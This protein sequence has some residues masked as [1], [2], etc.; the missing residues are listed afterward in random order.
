MKI[1]IIGSGWYGC[2]LAL[3][4]KKKGH[5]V[6]IYEKN[7]TIFSGI[8]GKF[9]IRLHA[10]PHYPR[11][12]ETRKSCQRGLI[13]FKQR[14]PDLVIEHEYSI[15]GLGKVDAEKNPSRIS[16]KQFKEVC[17]ETNNCFEIDPKMRGYQDL[18][19]VVEID[20][21]SIVLGD[22]L[23]NKFLLEL[24][25]AKIPI[26]FNTR[27]NN[28]SNNGPS[29]TIETDDEFTSF[30]RVINATGY[31][32]NI[33]N[34][35]DFPVPIEVTYQPCVALVYEDTKPDKKPFSF[36]IIDGWFPCLMPVIDEEE[37]DIIKSRKYILTHG[38]WTIMGS[39]SSEAEASTLLEYLDDDFIKNKIKTY[40]QHEMERFWPEFSERF[41][42]VGWKSEVIAKLK[43]KREFRSAI[44][45]EKNGVIHIIP[46][47]VS[48]IFDVEREINV[49]LE[50]K[51]ADNLRRTW[52]NGVSS[53]FEDSS[54]IL[55][56]NGYKYVKHG[57]LHGSMAEIIE[58]PSHGEPNTC[59]IQTFAEIQQEEKLT[60]R[61]QII[62]PPY[63]DLKLI[64]E[65]QNNIVED[66]LQ[67]TFFEIEC[68]AGIAGGL[69]MFALM[70]L[71]LPATGPA[72]A[73]ATSSAAVLGSGYC[74]YRLFNKNILEL[75][76]NIDA[77]IRNSIINN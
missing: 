69:S 29:V 26:Y 53:L 48:N 33:P 17:A 72:I 27:V 20:E 34:T 56:Y 43:T 47:K 49:L 7:R 57:V 65:Y 70:L 41:K 16:E 39:Y 60:K 28:I 71:T 22:R 15:Y 42:Y 19:S 11:S 50:K 31:K 25:K 10:G 64:R 54:I 67:N 40:A 62:I 5:D 12:L 23:R 68:F 2:H 36:I 44:T 1:G 45:Y 52:R 59:S 55:S 73:A 8:S 21:P 6:T 14:Y 63:I 4:L 75:T 66:S 3:S 51:P 13:E 77:P 24:C 35:D 76:Q 18:Q 30:D 9:G 46:G 58:K 32:S 37:S 61:P 74:A 38:K